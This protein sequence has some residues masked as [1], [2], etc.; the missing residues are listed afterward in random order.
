MTDA[1]RIPGDAEPTIVV[2][3]DEPANLQIIKMA[4]VREQFRC[5]LVLLDGAR[6]GL[7][8]L[9]HHPVDLLLLDVVMPGMNGFEMFA[10]LKAEPRWADIPVIFLS[11][12]N[13]T[14]YIIQGLE[15]GAVDYIG[16]PLISQVLTAR[17]RSVLRMKFLQRELRKRNQELEDANRL[18]DEFL[19]FCSHDLRAPISAIELTCQFLSDQFV[20]DTAGKA[21]PEAQEL[22]ERIVNQTRL[23]RRLVENLLDMNKIEEGRV[24]PQPTFFSPRELLQGCV[25]DHQPMIL[26][27][28]LAIEE[29]LPAENIV[30]FGDREMIAQAIRNV[31]GN[32]VKF[33]RKRIRVLSR[34]E[35]AQAE[36]GGLWRLEIA[37]DGMGL[38]PGQ[39]EA[40]FNKYAKSDLRGPGYGLGLYIAQQTIRLHHG[41]I[42]ARS[43]EASRNARRTDT[44][45]SAF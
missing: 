18:K 42:S 17:F 2:I 30:C 45:S 27:R 14:R 36:A 7:D 9:E 12:V 1:M 16:K 21:P 20:T 43:R 35:G 6:K 4:V 13:E 29:D 5:N 25:Q 38:P 33:A 32:A 23:A 37:D 39:E 31:L 34:V 26:A 24:V 22:L 41:T 44:V 10:Q 15:M 40:I 11:A 8:F 28:N 3:D 19:S